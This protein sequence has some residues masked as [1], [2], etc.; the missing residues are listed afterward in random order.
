MRPA[1]RRYCCT[2]AA[3]A[4]ASASA[5]RSQQQLLTDLGGLCLQRWQLAAVLDYEV[6]CAAEGGYELGQRVYSVL[7]LD[8][9][10]F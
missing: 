5:P 9:A 8:N 4:A 7:R 6:L 2:A 10:L 1:G 3:T